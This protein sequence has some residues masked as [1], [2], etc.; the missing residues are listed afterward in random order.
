MTHE[1]GCSREQVSLCVQQ[2][3]WIAIGTSAFHVPWEP[4]LS[5]QI[6]VLL[7]S[8]KS[9]SEPDPESMTSFVFS[10]RTVLF[11]PLGAFDFFF[12]LKG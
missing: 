12:F 9:H 1:I 8:H 5:L 3:E 2:C 7:F 6:L 4:V 11:K 10:V